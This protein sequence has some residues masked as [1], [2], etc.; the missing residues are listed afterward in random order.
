M[1]G[2]TDYITAGERVF[3]VDNG[4]KYLG[5]VTG[6]GCCLG[7]TISAMIASYASDKLAATLAGL[8]LYNIAAEIAAER[9]DVKGPG[10]FVPAFLDELYNIRV[11]S[12]KG[13]FNWLKRAKL[14][15]LDV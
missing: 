6:T 7:T 12:V 4:H 9:D 5:M 11:A 8:L 1:T 3:T 10:S 13:D 14:G 2:K 15:I